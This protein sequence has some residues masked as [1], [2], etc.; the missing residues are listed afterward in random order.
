MGMIK[1]LIVS[2]EQPTQQTAAPSRQD[3]AITKEWLLKLLILCSVG[4][5]F[6]DVLIFRLAGFPVILPHLLL[7]AAVSLALLRRQRFHQG[8]A[9]ACAMMG[10]VEVLHAAFFG[11]ITEAEWLKSFAQYVVYSSACCLLAGLRVNRADLARIAPWV[12]RLAILLAG[13]G[14]AQFFALRLGVWPVLPF[15]WG[16]YDPG[17]DLR[18]GGFGAATAFALEPSHFALGLVGLAALLLF[19]DK[20]G[21]ISNRK[22][23][24]MALVMLFGG[25]LVSFSMTGVFMMTV[26]VLSASLNLSHFAKRLLPALLV[27][28]VTMSLFAGSI[29]NVIQSR[30]RGV[31]AG[32]DDSALVRVVAATELTFTSLSSV[33]TSWF[34]TGLGM[35]QREEATYT[36][37]YQENMNRPHLL[38]GIKIHNIFATVRFFQGWIGLVLYSLVLWTVVR[39]MTSNW[40]LAMPLGLFLLMYHFASGYYLT[41]SF[42]TMLSLTVILGKYARLS[43][44]ALTTKAMPALTAP[45]IAARDCRQPDPESAMT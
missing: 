33:E 12:S 18:L 35:E 31:L 22:L 7:A 38:I 16:D 39:P 5:V 25:V 23:W 19:L 3:R 41:P 43:Q 24:Y 6:T 2:S 26:L 20:A 45:A 40:R 28:A 32:T 8:L 44:V 11:L 27:A 30:I 4:I 14:I 36:R 13:I 17:A 37:V 34:G 1:P 15:H 9:L 29:L 42:W 21:V 10:L